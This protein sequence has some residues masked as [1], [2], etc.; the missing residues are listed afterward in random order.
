M[1]YDLQHFLGVDFYEY[2][3]GERPWAQFYRF[4]ARLPR[5]G[6]FYASVLAD[7]ESVAEMMQ[8]MSGKDTSIPLVGWTTDHD[9]L[10]T[11]IDALNQLHATLVQVNTESGKRP[12]VAF[13]KRPDTA[14]ARVEARRSIEAHRARVKMMTGRG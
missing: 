13:T 5:H 3:R 12:D 10:S 4:I 2:I 11:I 8:R 14:I 7:E 6:H 9:L 1:E